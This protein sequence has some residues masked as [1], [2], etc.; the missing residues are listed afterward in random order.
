[1]PDKTLSEVFG[2]IAD[3][4]RE[5]TESQEKFLSEV[6]NLISDNNKTIM[7]II[8]EEEI[9]SK[10]SDA[11]I[12]GQMKSIQNDLSILTEGM[13]SIQGKQFKD[14]CRQLLKEDHIISLN[15]FENLSNEIIH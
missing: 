1:M 12:N 13:L 15:E 10:D 14:E 8:R 9:A 2:D 4:I 5:K 6:K 7:K 11:N 3:A